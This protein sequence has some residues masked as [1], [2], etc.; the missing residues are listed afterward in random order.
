MR[1]ARVSA[2]NRAMVSVALLLSV[3]PIPMFLRLA[4]QCHT[5]M[6]KWLLSYA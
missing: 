2:T 5:G 3:I 6:E 4:A 1:S